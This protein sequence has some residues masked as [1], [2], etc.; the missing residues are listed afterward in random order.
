MASPGLETEVTYAH[1][2]NRRVRVVMVPIKVKKY[3]CSHLSCESAMCSASLS[4]ED[5]QPV[6]QRQPAALPEEEK[7]LKLPAIHEKPS[8]KVLLAVF[9]RPCNI[10]SRRIENREMV[11]QKDTCLDQCR[12]QE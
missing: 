1:V 5:P 4:Q 11:I 2:R 7:P 9:L 3:S 6:S 8:I 12:K 10:S